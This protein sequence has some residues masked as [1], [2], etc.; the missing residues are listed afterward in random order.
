MKFASKRSNRYSGAV[1]RCLAVATAL[2]CLPAA[3]HATSYNEG[4]VLNPTTA[5]YEAN[6]LSSIGS[7]PTNIGSLTLGSN[8]ITGE[9]IPY[10]PVANVM[11]GELTYQDNDYVTFTVPTGD[12]LSQLRLAAGSSIVAGDRF[13]IGLASGSSV[14]VMPPSSSG[15]LGFTLATSDM[16]NSDILPAIGMASPPGFTG[17]PFSGATTFSGALPSG[18]YSLWLLDGDRPVSYNLD[19]QVSAAPEPSTWMMLLAG[20]G[21]MGLALRRRSRWEGRLTA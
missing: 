11:T 14:N 18:T 15:L 8:F 13:F 6:D 12:V 9:T 21:A 5:P 1:G 20:V 16:I 2:A 3:A 7:S 17:P 10:G 4:P 19:L